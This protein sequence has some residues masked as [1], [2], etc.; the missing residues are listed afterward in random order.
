MDRNRDAVPVRAGQ[1]SRCQRLYKD[2]DEHQRG[3]L[4]SATNGC[5]QPDGRRPRCRNVL[6]DAAAPSQVANVRNG[7]GNSQIS[8]TGFAALPN[9]IP[10]HT[11][12]WS[13]SPRRPPDTVGIRRRA[14]RGPAHLTAGQNQCAHAGPEPPLQ[15]AQPRRLAATLPG[16]RGA[17]VRRI[18][19][20]LGLPSHR[21]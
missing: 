1:S 12:P 14:G 8:R 15:V 2:R 18:R 16:E 3:G 5:E 11:G 20:R 10:L 4:S 19:Q 7:A 21:R 17:D 13:R 6:H 9:Y